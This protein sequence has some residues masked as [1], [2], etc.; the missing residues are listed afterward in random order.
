MIIVQYY[1]EAPAVSRKVHSWL[2][3]SA[4]QA[5]HPRAAVASAPP[6]GPDFAAAAAEVC[7]VRNL[8]TSRVV[9]ELHFART[10]LKTF[11]SYLS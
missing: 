9:P 1:Q 2:R 5:H 11:P 3:A 6:W 7:P 10:E 8:E 4:E